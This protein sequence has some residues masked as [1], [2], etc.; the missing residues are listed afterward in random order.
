M[1]RLTI[2][3]IVFYQA[4]ILILFG[5]LNYFF[6]FSDYFQKYENLYF[7][8]WPIF[9]AI[10]ISYI[11]LL[12]LPSK[13]FYSNLFQDESHDDLDWDRI[14][15]Q[16]DLKNKE[17]ETLSK[18]FSQYDHVYKGVIDS[19]HNIIFVIDKDLNIIYANEAFKLHFGHTQQ[20]KLIETVRNYKLQQFIA[21]SILKN[22]PTSISQFCFEQITASSLLYY[23]VNFRPL[24]ENNLFLIELQDITEKVSTDIIRE[25]FVA[26]FS[27]EVKTPISVIDGQVQLLAD[28]FASGEKQKANEQIDKIVYNS[29]RLTKLFNDILSFTALDK[30]KTS[31]PEVFNFYPLLENVFEDVKT[32]Y[33]NKSAEIIS[34]LEIE[35]ICFDYHQFEQVLYN[36]I[37]NAFKYSKENLILSV[38]SHEINN[39]IIID[40]KDNGIGIKSEHLLR[41]FERFYRVDHSHSSLIPGSG[42]GLSIVKKIIAKHAG[43]I[44]VSSPNEQGTTFTLVLPKKTN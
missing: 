1:N 37:E 19:F 42:L 34:E 32:Q 10:Y 14:N 18:K 33:P 31:K 26:N 38:K 4:L 12:L 3:K 17:I 30:V 5:A 23:T 8:M 13:N 24:K 21:D 2:N 7:I 20:R 35:D 9:I 39:N 41:I 15:K 28:T 44:T 11:R 25:E 40:F 6:I 36:I 16:L 43:K 29:R 27:H 22:I